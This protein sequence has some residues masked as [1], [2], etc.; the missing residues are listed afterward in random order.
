MTKPIRILHMI[1]S[2]DIGGSQSMVLNLY[3]QIDKDRIQFDFI[4]DHAENNYLLPKVKKLGAKVYSLPAF[5]GKNYFK[6]RSAWDVFLMEH[7]EYKVLHSH[8]RSYASIYLPIAK[9]HG[10]KTII[11]SHSTSNGSGLLSYAKRILQYPLRFQADYYFGCSKEAGEWLFGKKI[12][13]SNKY[14]MVKNAV[15]VEKYKLNEVIRKIYRDKLNVDDNAIVFLHVG[16]LHESKNHMFLLEIYNEIQ[17]E[18]PNSMLLI[19]GDGELKKQIEGKIEDLNIDN[20]VKM[21]GAR[22]DVAE[23]M[24]AADVFLFPSVWE[25]LPVTVVEA[26]AAGLP[27]FVSET[28][29]KDVN[30]TEL[31]T[32]LPIN[33]GA[34]VWKKTI[35]NHNLEKRDVISDIM[36][37]GFDIQNSAEW[38]SEFYENLYK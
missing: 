21:L 23:I 27:C 19:V 3:K 13:Q 17:K 8:I 1:G 22:N 36:K 35:I 15:A 7:P 38:I 4:L 10:L 16:R 11:H 34:Q 9:K 37:K 18:I 31:V 12:I 26:Q 32:N 20:N 28:I 2:L 5:N 29:T 6:V 30:V 25:G 14:Y 33:Q 24:Q